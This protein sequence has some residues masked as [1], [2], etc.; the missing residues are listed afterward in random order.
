MDQWN[1][2]ARRTSFVNSHGYTVPD[3]LLLNPMGSVWPLFGGE[4]F[5]DTLPRDIYR[6]MGNFMHLEDFRKIR[7]IDRSY[8]ALINELT[9]HRIEFLIADEHYL[10]GMQVSAGGT[11]LAENHEFSSLVLPDL[12]CLRTA[13]AEQILNFIRSGGK[14]FYHGELPVASAESGL[15]DP[16][17]AGLVA[18][19]AENAVKIT[20]TGEDG[21]PVLDIAG[22]F[23]PQ[24]KFE[25]G[26]FDMYQSHR[27]IDGR[28]F[29]WLVNNA[30]E[31]QSCRLL[32]RGIGGRVSK[33][34]CTDGSIRPLHSV[35]GAEGSLVDL[36]FKPVEAFWLVFEE[37]KEPYAREAEEG[38]AGH[39]QQHEFVLEIT[40]DWTVSLDPDA[41]PEP[42]K[43]Q[44][45]FPEYAALATGTK[46]LIPWESWGLSYFTGYIDYDTE[47][48]VESLETGSRYY[49]DLGKVNNTAEVWVNGENAGGR[50]W[51]PFTF[52]I[53]QQLVQGKNTVRVK[54]GNTM[55]N[56]M[57]YYLDQGTL[58]NMVWVTRHTPDPE[59][60]TSGMF[61]PVVLRKGG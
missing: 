29:F 42:F 17:L 51:P 35:S 33:W 30:E 16:E 28:H 22:H 3:V 44:V 20:V 60:I 39:I 5:H 47:F 54:T 49:I 27:E 19:I 7:D 59:E 61:G 41:Q 55:Y 6:N 18:E 15:D 14:V 38:A 45:Q 40:G 21:L 34:D 46:S 43:N 48:I 32:V 25:S 10:G 31:Y 57:R 8:A 2:F 13:T 24:I 53:T 1:D 36:D 26:S 4:I 56:V 9:G 58:N 50:M 37:D 12:F 23:A 52:D 11:L